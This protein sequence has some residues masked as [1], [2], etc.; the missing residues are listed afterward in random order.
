MSTPNASL[1]RSLFAAILF[2][3]FLESARVFPRLPDRM[4]SH[5]GFSG[6]PNGWMAKPAF[7][8]L[9][10]I[11][12]ALAAVVEFL[13]SRSIAAVPA[14]IRLPHKEY[15][16]APERR[17]QSLEFL[18]KHFAWYGCAFLLLQVYA[19][20][21]VIH[22]NLHKAARLPSGMILIAIAMFIL[23]NVVWVVQIF[24]RFSQPC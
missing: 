23:F 8:V 14:K 21:L 16:L 6:A 17:A 15:W 12:I 13:M 2:V 9:Y 4:A 5:F 24:R 10:S 22:A 18:K 11:V 19:M 20:E 1:P 7:F 3:A